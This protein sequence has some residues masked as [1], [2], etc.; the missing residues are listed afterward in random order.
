MNQK[1]GFYGWLNVAKML[2]RIC[3]IEISQSRI[4]ASSRKRRGA[5]PRCGS[6]LRIM[7][8]KRAGIS[9]PSPN[10]AEYPIPPEIYPVIDSDLV[11]DNAGETILVIKCEDYL[12]IH[13]FSARRQKVPVRAEN[14]RG[15][16]R[17]SPPKFC[18]KIHRFQK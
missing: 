4:L 9:Q 10:L 17:C 11:R 7:D 13:S 2:F 6:S 8:K 15:R 18:C 16:P 1:T 12:Q 5:I 3:Q 14:C